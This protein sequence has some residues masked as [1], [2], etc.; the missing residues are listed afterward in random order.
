MKS[1]AVLVF[2]LVNNYNHTVIDG[3]VSFFEDKTDVRLLVAPVRI[4]HSQKENYDYQFWSSARLL[5][6]NQIDGMILI[7]NSFTAYIDFDELSKELEIFS[8]KPVVSISRKTELPGSKYTYNTSA[9]AYE[10]V[11]EHLKNKHN[12][13]RIAFFGAGLTDSPESEERFDSFKKALKKNNLEFYPDLVFQGDFTPGTAEEVIAGKIKSKEDVNFDAICCVNDFTAG[14]VLY[15]FEKINVSCPNDVVIV[16]YDDSD[17]AVKLFPKLTSINQ[18]VV[19]TGFK[20]AELLYKTL[21]G[22]KTEDS[23]HTDSYPIYRQSCGCIDCRNFTTAYYD[24]VGNFYEKDINHH[25][26][27]VSSIKKHQRHLLH[28]YD[29]VNLINCNIP[30]EEVAG[31][32]KSAMKLSKFSEIAVYLYSDPL[33]LNSDDNFDV[34]EYSMLQIKSNMISTEFKF[35][36]SGIGKF[37]IS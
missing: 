34:P 18:S 1:I 35:N 10:M 8:G 36:S 21:N 15:H 4:P 5:Q 6:S 9:Y 3:I 11:I 16:G 23:I 2:N 33:E 7:P 25:K 12:C 24:H 30:M 17:Y 28:I 20:A 37:R 14:G 22:D 19:Q 13:K 26:A 27:E 31:V 32:L 29:I